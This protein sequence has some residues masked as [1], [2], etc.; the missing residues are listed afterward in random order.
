MDYTDQ[1][2]ARIADIAKKSKLR[3]SEGVSDPAE[4][5]SVSLQPKF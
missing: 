3:R 2:I 1:E 5:E 4:R